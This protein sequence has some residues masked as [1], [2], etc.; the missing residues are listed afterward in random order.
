MKHPNYP[1]PE[2]NIIYTLRRVLDVMR[3]VKIF[4]NDNPDA[5]VVIEDLEDYIERKLKNSAL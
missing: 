4:D 2:E 5:D 3:I 1:L